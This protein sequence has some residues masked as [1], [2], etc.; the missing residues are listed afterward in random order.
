MEMTESPFGAGAMAKGIIEV[1][2]DDLKLC[3]TT[4]GD[5]PK[6]FEAKEGSNAH[7]FV[8]KRSK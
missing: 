2:G 5:A 8:L 1:K 3:Y 7:S 6:N 4:E